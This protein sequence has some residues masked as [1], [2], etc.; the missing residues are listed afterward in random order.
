MRLKTPSGVVTLHVQAV[1]EKPAAY[2]GDFYR[3]SCYHNGVDAIAEH[4][5]NG[6]SEVQKWTDL[7]AMVGITYRYWRL[8][9]PYKVAETP[10]RQF[11]RE[12]LRPD[13]IKK[14]KKYVE[15]S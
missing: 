6:L 8:E 11:V 7:I 4:M 12:Y 10:Y 9:N 1:M 5:I 2:Q 15:E 13:I 14:L 3:I